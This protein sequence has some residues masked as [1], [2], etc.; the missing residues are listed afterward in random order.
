MS[1]VNYCEI[2]YVKRVLRVI[3]VKYAPSFQFQVREILSKI[4]L[5]TKERHLIVKYVWQL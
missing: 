4:K 5:L 2:F 1:L 3:H